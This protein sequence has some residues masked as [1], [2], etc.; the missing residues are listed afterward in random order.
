MTESTA[1]EKAKKYLVRLKNGKSIK[2]TEINDLK[3]VI[4]TLDSLSYKIRQN[5][6]DSYEKK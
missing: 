2:K 4:E 1:L 5:E 6:R 3:I